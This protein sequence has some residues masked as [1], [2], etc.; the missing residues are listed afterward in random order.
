MDTKPGV[1]IFLADPPGSVLFSYFTSERKLMDRA[2]SS[3]TEGI[4]QGRITDNLAPDVDLIDGALHIKDEDTIAMVYR[5]L[6]EE[7]TGKE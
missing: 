3:I 6:D 1:K 5:L 7:A 4:G 2:G